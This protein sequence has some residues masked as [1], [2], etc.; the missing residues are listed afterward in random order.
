MTSADYAVL[1]SLLALL[2]SMLGWFFTY[3]KQVQLENL[4]GD[5]AKVLSEH[6]TRFAY[7]HQRRGEVIDQLYKR[8]VKM[9]RRLN[10][11]LMVT[12][13]DELSLNVERTESH[14][15]LYELYDYYLENRIYLDEELCKQIDALNKNS[16]DALEHTEIGHQY[17]DMIRAY[18]DRTKAIIANEINPLL[19][20]IEKQ[21]R[22]ILGPN[23]KTRT[24]N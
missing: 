24:N 10:K 2:V 15:I 9:R 12:V 17:P 5:I 22:E 1:A 4:K 8:I 16:G 3:R 20:Q 6:D 19:G 7:L 18:R 14:A 13:D 23:S 21:M 11:S